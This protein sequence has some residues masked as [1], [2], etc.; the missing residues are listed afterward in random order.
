MSKKLISLI[1]LTSMGLVACGNNSITET[2]QNLSDTLN[3]VPSA[4]PSIN[5]ATGNAEV[6]G[7]VTQLNDL[8]QQAWNWGL[9]SF[10]GIIDQIPVINQLV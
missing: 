2:T 1:P 10:Q 8:I 7:L 6:D 4:A 9:T 3:Q 5:V